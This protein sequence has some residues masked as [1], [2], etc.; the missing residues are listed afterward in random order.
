MSLFLANENNIFFIIYVLV[1][2]SWQVL[3]SA[4]TISH[5][6]AGA[7]ILA[8]TI[9]SSYH[10]VYTRGSALSSFL[11]SAAC[12]SPLWWAANHYKGQNTMQLSK[13]HNTHSANIR[14]MSLPIANIVPSPYQ[15]RKAF[16][17]MSLYQLSQSIKENGLLQ[18]IAVRQTTYG[19]YELIAGER[20]L[21]ASRI[22]GLSKISAIIIDASDEQSAILCMVENVQRQQLH[23]FE[24]A[25]GYKRLIE[26]HSM[27]QVQLARQLG[28][29]QSTIANKIRLLR[30]GTMTKDIIVLNNL[31][32]RH[33]RALLRLSGDDERDKLLNIII[34]KSLNVQA[35]DSL[36]NHY[37]T[38]KHNQTQKQSIKRAYSDWRLLNNSVKSLIAKM[39][40]SGTKISYNILDLDT[41]V[42]MTIVIDK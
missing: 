6:H 18:P 39:K 19:K 40:Q 29:Q 5:F 24:V 13:L 22:A 38:G 32:E 31:T 37:L 27:T 11:A 21:R 35:T 10:R 9:V 7:G 1:Y 26:V 2:Y 28:V 16:D 4:T 15:S 20:R 3:V 12:F 36:V 14:L 8:E 34:K 33:A 41:Q 30:L 23:F 17:K 25:Q 42:Q